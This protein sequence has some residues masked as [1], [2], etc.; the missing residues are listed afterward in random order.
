MHNENTPTNSPRPGSVRSAL[1]SR[2][3]R[4]IFICSFSSQIG[5]WMQ[6][7]VLPAYI[8]HRT[9]SAA[10]VAYLVFAQLGPQLILSIPA[11]VMAD[12]YDRRKWLFAMQYIQITCSLGLAPL[13]ASNAPIW[14]L[15]VM[16]LGV[17]IG[18]SLNAPAWSALL[19]SL[20][21]REDL[22]GAISLNSTVING[23]RVIGPI[24]VALLSSV[25]VTTAEFFVINAATYLFV[26]FALAQ[27]TIPPAVRHN[28]EEGW[29]QFTSGIR[30]VRARPALVR[31]LLTMCSF[32]LL[33]LS[34]VGLF[35]A[36]ARNNFHIDESTSLYR[37]LYATWAFGAFAGGL[38][39][40][41]FFVAYDKRKLVQAGFGMFAVG[42]VGFA[43]SGSAVPAFITGAILGFAYFFTTTSMNTILQSRLE[44][45]VRGR[46][47]SLWF[48]AFGG[49][50]P[51]GNMIFGPIIDRYGVKTMLFIGAAWSLVLMWWCNLRTVDDKFPD[52]AHLPES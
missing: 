5:T 52:G 16:Q 47:M 2:D 12:K 10:M 49:T 40:G 37:W 33:S 17:G 39:L 38:S 3:F 35:P 48:L 41:T 15:F 43:L 20:V 45:S 29:R 31:L 27:I 26:V 11:G 14:M 9:D 18:N 44:Q 8:Y 24:I 13:A 4:V 28:M 22:P 36:V 6:N 30:I 23:S 7:V 42:M 1:R 34:Y 25:G 51:I 19:P 21:P 46:V 50:I 32:S